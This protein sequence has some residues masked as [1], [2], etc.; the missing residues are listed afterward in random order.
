MDSATSTHCEPGC[1][2]ALASLVAN[3]EA[4][5]QTPPLCCDY[6]I[7]RYQIPWDMLYTFKANEVSTFE[8]TT[9]RANT[10][11][12]SAPLVYIFIGAWEEV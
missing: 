8:N 2:T 3:W 11:K 5:F 10:I 9:V 4:K 1:S 12:Q 6:G 7:K